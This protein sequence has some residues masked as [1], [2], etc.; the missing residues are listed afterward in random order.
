MT[1]QQAKA[2]LNAMRQGEA[3]YIQEMK[4]TSAK[5]NSGGNKKDW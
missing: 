1:E 2:I 4:R 3:Q 5:P